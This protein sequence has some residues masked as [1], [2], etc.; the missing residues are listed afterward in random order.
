[1]K[2]EAVLEKCGV[3]QVGNFY[4]EDVPLYLVS[5]T[6]EAIL[7]G[8]LHDSSRLQKELASLFSAVFSETQ[9]ADPLATAVQVLPVSVQTDLFLISPDMPGKDAQIVSVTL[10]KCSTCW[11]EWKASEVFDFGS[12]FRTYRMHPDRSCKT[13][14]C[15]Y[16]RVR[17][18]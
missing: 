7:K 6:S 4:C 1:M 14:M 9:A 10:D 5:F 2:V 17:F 18:M 16:H 8:F 15:K 13:G 11:Q 3:S 12:L